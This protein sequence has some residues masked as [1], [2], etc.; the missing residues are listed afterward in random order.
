MYNHVKYPSFLSDLNETS[1]FFDRFWKNYQISN[2]MKIRPMG[3]QFQVGGRTD[4]RTD[5]Q[6]EKNEA[7]SCISQILR[8]HL[9]ITE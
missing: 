2:F 4:R 1:I 5:R 7:I 9:N 8:T 6:T 3:A